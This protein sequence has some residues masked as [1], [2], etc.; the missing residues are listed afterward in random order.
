MDRVMAFLKTGLLAAVAAGI[1]FTGSASGGDDATPPELKLL[2]FTPESIDTSTS[3]AE[4]TITFTVTDDAS[5]ANYF[6][7]SFVEFFKTKP[8][9]NSL[10][11]KTDST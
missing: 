3:A 4:V 2:R 8:G 9:H 7:A 10:S 11:V 1:V 6:E 5:G